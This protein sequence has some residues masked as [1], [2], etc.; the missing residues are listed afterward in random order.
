L[1]DIAHTAALLPRHPRVYFEEWNDP[2]ISGIRWVSELIAIAGGDDC[3]AELAAAHAA[4]GRIIA[5][6]NSVIHRAPEIIIGSW[7]GK[8]FRPEQVR[9]RPGWETIPAVRDGQ[10]HEVK[11]CDILQ[12]GPAALTDGVQQLHAIV[13]RW[14]KDQR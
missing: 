5:D 9:K 2:L 14:V 6:A 4:K 11:S 8:H 12:P 1:Q 13:R 10:V 3:F 7:C